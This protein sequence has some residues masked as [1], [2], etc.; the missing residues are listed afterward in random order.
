V[1]ATPTLALLSLLFERGQW[2][3]L[4][5]A[6]WLELA[7]PLY[8]AIGASLIGHGIL[9]YLLGRYPVGVTTPLMLLSPVLAVGFGV[10]LWSDTLTW[11]LALGGLLTLAGLAIITIPGSRRASASQK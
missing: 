11:K 7:A 5:T 8:S 4:Q 1:Y 2:V 10:W 9:Y 6:T 3:A